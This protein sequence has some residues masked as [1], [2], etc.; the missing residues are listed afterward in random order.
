MILQGFNT[1][2][3]MCIKYLTKS[4]VPGNQHVSHSSQ[5]RSFTTIH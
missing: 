4:I 3:P 2:V 1:H 5:S